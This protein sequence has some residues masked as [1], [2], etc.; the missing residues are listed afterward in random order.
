MLFW[1]EVMGFRRCEANL[2]IDIA[3]RQF[4]SRFQALV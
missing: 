1:R 4:L 2:S 3:E